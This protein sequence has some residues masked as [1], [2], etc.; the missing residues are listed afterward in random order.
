MYKHFFSTTF[1]DISHN[2]KHCKMKSLNFYFL[3]E[4]RGSKRIRFL[5]SS[6]ATWVKITRHRYGSGWKNVLI[7]RECP[8][9]TFMTT[10][11]HLPL[12]SKKNKKI[13]LRARDF[14]FSH[15][16]HVASK[17]NVTFVSVPTDPLSIWLEMRLSSMPDV[18]LLSITA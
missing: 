3:Q 10:N 2:P 15:E 11:T 12:L 9:V 4:L 16:F 5:F 6:N 14:T 13:K 18:F 1:L 8:V 17:I 7:I